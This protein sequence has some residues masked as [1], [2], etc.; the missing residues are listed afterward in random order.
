MDAGET[1]SP[2]VR[3]TNSFATVFLLSSFVSPAAGRQP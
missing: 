2:V 1:I 3:L